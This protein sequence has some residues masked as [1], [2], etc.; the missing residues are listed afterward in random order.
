MP[1]NIAALPVT[2]E[3]VVNCQFWPEGDIWKGVAD[4]IGIT[5]SGP[6]F[7]GAKKNMQES[8]QEYFQNLLGK[9]LESQRRTAA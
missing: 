9:E 1:E 6:T 3:M 7:E 8:L 5:I 4:Q 2:V